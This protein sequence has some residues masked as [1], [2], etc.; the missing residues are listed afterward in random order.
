VKK[1]F[2]AKLI[3]TISAALC[4]AFGLAACSEDGGV[5]QY[6]YLLND[7]EYAGQDFSERINYDSE[8]V[9][10]AKAEPYL[11]E[12]A[13]GS[14]FQLMR[15]GYYKKCTEQGK[16]CLSEIVSLKYNFNNFNMEA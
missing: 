14:A 8:H 5:K 12:A 13:D 3:V 4:F 15:T 16:L 7:A 11:N 1:H 9:F 2:F 10:S 6:D